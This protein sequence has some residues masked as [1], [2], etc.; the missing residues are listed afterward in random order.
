MRRFP[1][2]ILLAA[3]FGCT[4]Q[5][6]ST[7]PPA[8]TP[9]FDIADAARAYKRGFYWLPPIVSSPSVGGTFDGTLSPTVEICELV[10]AACGPL[11]AR[12]TTTSG[13]NGDLVQVQPDDQLYQVNWHTNEF[14]LSTSKI[15]RVSVRAGSYNTLLGY[16][17]VQ[18]V[19]TGAALKNVDT[20]EYIGLKDGRTLPIKFRI[21]TGIVGYI[22]VHPPEATVEPGATQQ[23][24]ATLTDLHGDLLDGDVTWASSDENVATVDQTGLAT[25]VNDGVAII[26]ATS[27]RVVGSAA[28]TVVGG[29]IVSTGLS[30]SCAIAPS[31]TAYCWGR[32]GNGQLG[33]GSN[34]PRLTPFPVAGGF[35]FA[36]V[37]T[38]DMHSCGLTTAG[39]AYCWGSDTDGA[40][41]TGDANENSLVP[42]AVASSQ[43][44]TV[45]DAGIG[46]TCALTTVGA[47]YCWGSG[48][49]GQLGN[50]DGGG[51]WGTPQ[52]VVGNLTF[53]SISAGGPTTCGLTPTGQAYCWGSNQFGRLGIGSTISGSNVPLLVSGG[54]LFASISAGGTHVCG[55]VTTG[56]AYCW[57]IG[58]NG[59]L[60]NGSNANRL[61]PTE[62]AGG[63]LFSSITVGRGGH[64]CA[65]ATEGQAYCWGQGTNGR[66]GDGA[67]LDRPTPTPVAGSLLFASISAGDTH[68]CGVTTDDEL[69]CWGNGFFGALGNGSTLTQLTPTLVAP[70][71]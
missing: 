29:F 60:G 4:D 43:S 32:G 50:G 67:T 14:S 59:R 21:E 18:P 70:L 68:T 15:Y 11:V 69:Y 12:Y 39:Q 33:N 19:S 7:A 51:A 5:P 41:G 24:V 36:A 42:A 31:G 44:F 48:L 57:G 25:A 9:R 62:V 13:P 1:L 66:L 20:D 46:T 64:T 47:A 27:D 54:L 56:Q 52:A 58:A 61:V 26:T 16:A 53:A 8:R 28:L 49:V 23:F 40:L 55:I 3:T 22:D 35:T 30:H 34:A 2:L 37:A 63:L 6:L 71:P 65:I 38:G 10:D 45:I 17:D